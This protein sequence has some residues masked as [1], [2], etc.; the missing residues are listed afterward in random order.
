MNN[1]KTEQ[2]KLP[3]ITIIGC[4]C[5]I[6]FVPLVLLLSFFIVDA[7]RGGVFSPK[8]PIGLRPEHTDKI[9]WAWQEAEE[10][11]IKED[12]RDQLFVGT[13]QID[14]PVTLRGREESRLEIK[15]EGTFILIDPTKSMYRRDFHAP[16]TGKW[17][18]A[19]DNHDR[20]LKIIFEPESTDRPQSSSLF[21]RP[22]VLISRR[23]NDTDD[24]YLRLKPICFWGSDAEGY[25]CTN[26]PTW[27]KVI[28]G[29]PV[30]IIEEQPVRDA[31]NEE[32]E[33]E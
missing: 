13:W 7:Y 19:Y 15:P 32:V 5:A 33:T 31:A 17:Q 22:Q 28:D 6:V 16:I 26:T 18:V 20:A 23:K 30:P 10:G 12:G 9:K 3:T 24:K 4:A 27:K 25:F 11:W 21:I 2:K 8:Y 29:K 14:L 1:V